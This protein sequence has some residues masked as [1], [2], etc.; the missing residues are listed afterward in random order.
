[1][2]FLG[3]TA[4]RFGGLVL[5]IG[6]GFHAN[7]S[8]FC[9]S[10]FLSATSIRGQQALVWMKRRAVLKIDSFQESERATG[11]SKVQRVYATLISPVERPARMQLSYLRLP[12]VEL[13]V[14]DRWR[15]DGPQ[16]AGA[17]RSLITE[18]KIRAHCGSG[19]TCRLTVTRVCMAIRR[20]EGNFSEDLVVCPLIRTRLRR[21]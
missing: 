14:L 9:R 8:L 3:D 20:S 2:S 5:R 1:V 19:C 6:S 13:P 17:G 4:P 7:V 21:G 11:W 18:A 10:R 12:V 15:Y 16:V